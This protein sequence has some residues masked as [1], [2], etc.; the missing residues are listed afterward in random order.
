[1]IYQDNM[2]QKKITFLE[3]DFL[4]LICFD[5]ICWYLVDCITV[6]CITFLTIYNLL[7]L[8]DDEEEGMI[9]VDEVEVIL[10]EEV[11]RMIFFEGNIYLGY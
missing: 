7:F 10:V 9:L 5:D 2:V 6:D 1:M 8:E 3:C 4:Y 11:E